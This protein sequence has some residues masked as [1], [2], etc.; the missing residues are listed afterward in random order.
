MLHNR[1]PAQS[2]LDK[3]KLLSSIEV[4]RKEEGSKFTDSQ[5]AVEAWTLHPY[6]TAPP[7]PRG[8]MF[9]ADQPS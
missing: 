6:R 3:D 8:R 9:M 1:L 7:D 4:G 5:I 2:V